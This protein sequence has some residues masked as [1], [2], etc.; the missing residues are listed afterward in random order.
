LNN[1]QHNYTTG[2]QEL[3]STVETLKEFKSVLRQRILVHSDHKNLL[4]KSLFTERLSRWPMLVE[5]Y[6]VEFVHIEG[7]DNVVSDGLSCLDADHKF[8]IEHL[9]II[10]DEQGIFSAFVWLI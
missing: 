3:L 9:K 8:K 4:Y 6:G 1:A 5:E 2:E 10:Q 7:V